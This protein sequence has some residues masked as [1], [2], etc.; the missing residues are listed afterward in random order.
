MQRK[1]EPGR[2]APS[3]PKSQNPSLKTQASEPNNPNTYGARHP[4]S[5]LEIKSPTPAL[6]GARLLR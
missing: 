6:A 2:P 3:K 5:P 4:G 1:G